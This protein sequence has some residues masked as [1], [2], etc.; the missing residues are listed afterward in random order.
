MSTIE[1]K[2]DGQPNGKDNGATS[3]FN[4][5]GVEPIGQIGS[6]KLLSILG[7]GGFSI[8]YLAEQDKDL[9]NRNRFI[10][11]HSIP[12]TINKISEFFVKNKVCSVIQGGV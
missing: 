5:S 7:E 3:S 8:V 6:Y 11:L 1:P 4:V 12:E 9:E 2:N 10:L